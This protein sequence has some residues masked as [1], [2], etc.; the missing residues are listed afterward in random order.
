MRSPIGAVL[1]AGLLALPCAAE[2]YDLTPRIALSSLFSD[3]VARSATNKRSDDVLVG[4]AGFEFR[5]LTPTLDAD[6]TA[7]D[8]YYYFVDHTLPSQ[9][10]PNVIG[11]GTWHIIPEYF[12]WTLEDEYG[13]VATE[14]FEALS[15][16][17]R[18]NTNYATTG[19]SFV[20]PVGAR[21][22]LNVEGRYSDVYYSVS[23]I[24]NT[25]IDGSAAL[26]YLFSP[27]HRVSINYDREQV[28]FKHS[29]LYQN[30][31]E[32]SVFGRFD[33]N[34]RLMS[35]RVDAGATEV[36]TGTAHDWEPLAAATVYREVGAY[37]TVGLEV[38]RQVSDAADSFRNGELNAVFSGSDINV[39]RTAATFVG[40]TYSAFVTMERP[41]GSL[42]L[43]LYRDD[44]TYQSLSIF[45]RKITG[46]DFLGSLNLTSRDLLTAELQYEHDDNENGADVAAYTG[47]SLELAHLITPSLRIAASVERYMRRSA[48]EGP[49]DEDR[50]GLTLRYQPAPRLLVRQF[51]PYHSRGMALPSPG[52]QGGAAPFDAPSRE[53]FPH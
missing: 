10:L 13:Q 32:Q 1:A 39:I 6:L 25:R 49:F 2:S 4:Q 28:N 19:P 34:V 15:P 46:A 50:I 29:D 51:A 9:Q 47:L 38:Q 31:V 17:D 52:G 43:Y 53:S 21:T 42:R 33:E 20:I 11:D 5:S 44:E 41:R 48:F 45:D 30:Y 36:S 7:S 35:V 18:E 12:A 3:N 16:G 23:D 40:Q 14:P 22:R 24:G 37:T 8:Q 27:L 26:E